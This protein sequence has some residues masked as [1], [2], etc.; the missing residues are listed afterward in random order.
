MYQPQVDDWQNF[1][2]IKWRSAFQL[3]PTGGKM[4]VGAATFEATTDVNT[5]NHMV[6][7]FGIQLLNA[8]F[9]SQD[10]S[11]S[12][13]LTQ[14][15]RSFIPPVFTI[16]LDRVVAYTPKPQSV[17][18]VDLKNDPPFIFVSYTPAI[19]LQVDGDPVLA[20][21]EHTDLKFVVNT[22]WPLFFDKSNSQYYLL[23]NNIWLT[24]GDLHGPWSQTKNLSREFKKIP[25]SGKFAAVKK[26][27]PPPQVSNPIIPQVFY[28][29]VPAEVILF[30]GQPTYTQIPGTQL[31]FLQTTRNARFSCTALRRHI[32]S[33]R[34]GGGSAHQPHRALDVRI[35]ESSRRFCQHPTQQPGEFHT[36]L[37]ARNIPGQRRS[38]DRANSHNYAFEPHDGRRSGESQLHRS[39][40]IRAN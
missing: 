7:M 39:T 1:L 10:P 13:N 9:P 15:V 12:A 20:D 16:S 40:A 4:I 23:V 17:K 33:L 24:S 2:D 8:Y 28:S 38:L 19:L 32:I 36:R 26:A 29:T 6:T 3:T 31:V 25:D 37:R 35:S 14:L 5:D 18:T 27:I 30:D 22:I 21:I 34:L 11:T